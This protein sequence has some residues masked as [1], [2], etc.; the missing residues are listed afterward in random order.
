MLLYIPGALAAASMFG[1]APL[2][3]DTED[4]RRAVD[5]PGMGK[6]LNAT[7]PPLPRLA[8]S[9]FDFALRLLLYWGMT[10][11]LR[12]MRAQDHIEEGSTYRQHR[13]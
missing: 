9:T 4:R 10:Y 13:A 1:A 8:T 6:P 11:A 2:R 7:S 5:L 12:K 3:S